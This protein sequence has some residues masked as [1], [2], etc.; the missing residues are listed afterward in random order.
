MIH[1]SVDEVVRMTISNLADN[2]LMAMD[3][4]GRELDRKTMTEF[5]NLYVKDTDLR[6]IY[7]DYFDNEI[8]LNSVKYGKSIKS[9]YK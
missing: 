4:A 1:K 9:N 7:Y 8:R 3:D 2:Y 5:V 6:Q